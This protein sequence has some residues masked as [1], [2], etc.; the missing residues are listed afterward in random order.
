MTGFPH[1]EPS[2]NQRQGFPASTQTSLKIVPIAK[3][4]ESTG[5]DQEADVQVSNF[6]VHSFL[7]EKFD[8][9]YY[10]L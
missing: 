5:K 6:R 4:P 9:Y 3:I 10:V 1:D 2:A 8:S 7:P